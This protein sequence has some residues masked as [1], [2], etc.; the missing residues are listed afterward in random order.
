MS[1]VFQACVCMC[2]G[3]DRV[4]PPV[5]PDPRVP[6]LPVCCHFRYVHEYPLPPVTPDLKP[7]MVGGAGQ[8]RDRGYLGPRLP[9]WC[10]EE[11]LIQGAADRCRGGVLAF[12]AAG[13]DR[14]ELGAALRRFLQVA[15]Q[16]PDWAG[17]RRGQYFSLNVALNLALVPSKALSIH[18]LAKPPGQLDPFPQPVFPRSHSIPQ[19]GAKTQNL[20][21]GHAPST[22]T[23]H[24][25]PVWLLSVL[26]PEN[27][28]G[29]VYTVEGLPSQGIPRSPAPSHACFAH[30]LT[31][32]SVVAPAS[33]AT[34]ATGGLRG[35]GASQ[36]PSLPNRCP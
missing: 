32:I 2:G 26:S 35:E 16:K 13:R 9:L 17:V 28:M 7:K 24:P 21:R 10:E 20:N 6:L 31:R 1:F 36:G 8:T 27:W 3:G 33:L 25:C 18:L 15:P 34:L 5:A 22:L 29:F 4:F 30:S 14:F 23:V 12:P 11:A 19:P